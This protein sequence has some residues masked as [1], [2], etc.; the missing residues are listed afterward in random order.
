MTLL[1]SHGFFELDLELVKVL[2]AMHSLAY[3]QLSYSSSMHHFLVFGS[4][5]AV[6]T[7]R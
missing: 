2:I 3:L 4:V 1:V 5:G 6:S 7:K